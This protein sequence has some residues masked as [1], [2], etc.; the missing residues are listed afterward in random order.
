MPHRKNVVIQ[1][2]Y[3]SIEECAQ[4]CRDIERSIAFFHSPFSRMIYGRMDGVD[5]DLSYNNRYSSSY[6]FVGRIVARDNDIYMEGDITMKGY[7]KVSLF[8]SYI[9]FLF[10][11]WSTGFAMPMALIVPVYIMGTLMYAHSFDGLY[12][13]LI[14]KVGA[15]Q[16]EPKTII[17]D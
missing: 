10:M 6:H 17:E 1:T 9:M 4:N 3:T 14:K 8:L 12:K 13:V 15:D 11:L 7:G 16:S 5:F 2:K